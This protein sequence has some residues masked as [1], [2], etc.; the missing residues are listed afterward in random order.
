M[1]KVFIAVGAVIVGL[2]VIGLGALL[3]GTIVYWLW[4]HAIPVVL[5]G[6]VA[7][8]A[9]A[10]SLAWWKAV[11]FTWICGILFKGSSTNSSK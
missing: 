11:M 9:V 10:G 8:G 3:G 4:P 1:D 5:P 2:L 6:L 7:S